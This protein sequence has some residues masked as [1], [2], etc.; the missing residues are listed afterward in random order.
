[1]TNKE[2]YYFTKLANSF[3]SDNFATKYDT[4]DARMTRSLIS[5]IGSKP[6]RKLPQEQRQRL[7]ATR[8][9]ATSYGISP[10]SGRRE[11]QRGQSNLPTAKGGLQ[12]IPARPDAHPLSSP[13]MADN[14]KALKP[15]HS[16]TLERM[17][18]GMPVQKHEPYTK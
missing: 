1:M 6:Y 3:H 14:E 12:N 18:R 15:F 9:H 5:Y 13:N 4:D 7:L 10:Q 2:K 16:N 11:I 17:D 8:D